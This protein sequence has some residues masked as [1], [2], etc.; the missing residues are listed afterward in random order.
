METVSGAAASSKTGTGH[1]RWFGA[2][3]S[4]GGPGRDALADS[5][6]LTAIVLL[7]SAPYVAGLGLYS[8][9]WAI[10][11]TMADAAGSWRQL[12][13]AVLPIEMDTRPVQALVLASLFALFGT[14]P[15]G[16]HIFNALVLAGTVVL[17]HLSLRRIGFARAPA[18]LIPLIFGLLPHYVTDRVWIAA[19]QANVSVLLYF[20]S[21]YAD[22]RFLRGRG[23]GAWAWKALGSIALAA[24]VLAYEVTAPL[25]LLNVLVLG[26]LAYTGY[27]RAEARPVLA[28]IASNILVLAAAIGYKLSTTVRADVSGGYVYRVLRIVREAVPV[29]FGELGVGLPLRVAQVL[30]VGPDVAV[31]VTAVVIGG[32]AAFWLHRALDRA[33]QQGERAM[34]WPAVVLLGAMLFFAGYGVTLMT[35]EIGFHATGANNRT[36]IAAA[37]GVSF[38]FAG[39]IGSL[40]GLLPRRA[41]RVT[42]VGLL[43]LL[44]TSCALI[45][46]TVARLW[47]EA[48]RVQ[49][50]VIAAIHDH[51]PELPPGS[52]LLLDGLCPYVGPAPV[53]ATGWDVTG[54]LRLEYPGS[55]PSGDVIKPNSEAT[56]HGLRTILFDDVIN[57]YPYGDDL[58]VLNLALGQVFHLEDVETARDYLGSVSAEARPACPPY[59]DG[60]G[61]NVF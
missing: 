17:F 5:L 47:V 29:H 44:A 59:T 46:G 19:F 11:A 50:A 55:D 20:V 57:V 49:E 41:G 48:D 31:A 54:M 6:F 3:P 43:G 35:W 13:A 58:R 39:A 2:G 25:L 14:E 52:T 45:T 27:P 23:A 37:I 10:L 21:L 7:S 4:A 24:S 56:P 42:F 60:D 36:A 38:V 16:Y 22:L 32:V 8:D 40:A 15:L 12:F 30:R 1:L 18:V 33:E 61:A 28:G 26:W 34:S 51:F 53:F 9:D